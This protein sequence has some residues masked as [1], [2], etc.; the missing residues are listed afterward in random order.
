LAKGESFSKVGRMKPGCGI[1][2]L[3]GLWG[4]CAAGVAQPASEETARLAELSAQKFRQLKEVSEPIDT[5][6]LNRPLLDAAVFHETNRRREKQGLPS[7]AFDPRVWQMARI[8]SQAMARHDFVSHDHPE[9]RKESISD[10]ARVVGLRP[11]VLAEN[12]ASSFDRRYRSGEKFYVREEA[13]R[14][15]ASSKPKGP[16]IPRHTFLSFAEALLD[17]WMDSPGHRENILS[18]APRYLGCAVEP[19]KG[20]GDDTPIRKLFATQVFFTPQKPFP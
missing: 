1:M 5:G 7:L 18:N 16:P 10:R 8:Q 2:L 3:I 14:R 9:P 20:E 13:G 19:G 11:A 12:V 17:Q 15:I 6:R 4:L